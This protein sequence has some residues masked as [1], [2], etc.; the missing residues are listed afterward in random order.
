MEEPKLAEG[1]VE[2]GAPNREVRFAL[3]EDDGD[4]D[5]NVHVLDGGSGYDIMVWF[6]EG[7]G[8]RDRR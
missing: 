6:S 5:A 7:V 4:V 8:A 2:E 1:G 3:V